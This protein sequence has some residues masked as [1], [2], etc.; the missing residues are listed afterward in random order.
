MVDHTGNK[1]ETL[2]HAAYCTG[3][4]QLVYFLCALE[5]LGIQPNRCTIVLYAHADNSDLKYCM[6]QIGHELGIQIL[7]PR[8]LPLHGVGEVM[9]CRFGFPFL[10]TTRSNRHETQR[11]LWYCRGIPVSRPAYDCLKRV[12][13]R[14]VFEYYD[15]YRSPIVSRLYSK[16][17]F[18]LRE[19]CEPSRFIK[20]CILWKLMTPDRYFMPSASLW[21]QYA[22]V[23]A[24]SSTSYIPVEVIQ[25]K[26]RLVGGI[27]DDLNT[28]ESCRWEPP[29]VVLATGMFAERQRDITMADEVRMYEDLLSTVRSVSRKVSI[30]TKT[31]PRTSVE[32]MRRLETVCARYDTQLFTG[33][34]LIEFTLEKSGRRDI[35][36][37]G[38][39]TTALLNTLSFGYGTALCLS[40]QFMA[41]YLGDGY[42]NGYLV[43]E[44]HMLMAAAGV[45]TLNSL[46]QLAERLE[47]QKVK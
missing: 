11:V 46:S 35:V 5:N 34:Q 18:H 26:I 25:H 28:Q 8:E 37:I 45:V 12:Q 16:N 19:I 6:F 22:P 30:L 14:R 44:D 24:R 40:Q 38:P 3:P 33:Q 47:A 27:L 17:S 4:V 1:A 7:E 2:T 36:V 41:S 20:Q 43:S 9:L 23:K 15:G 42:A 13:P 39:P 32:K 31:H 10:R 21:Q 29:G